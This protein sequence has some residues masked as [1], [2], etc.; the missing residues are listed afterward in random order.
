MRRVKRATTWVGAGAGAAALMVG[1]STLLGFEDLSPI[2]EDASVPGQDADND[3]SAPS[4]TSVGEDVAATETG[5]DSAPEEDSAADASQ[6]EAASEAGSCV[7]TKGDPLNCGACGHDCLGGTCENGVCQPVQL[8]SGLDEPTDMVVFDDS[9]LVTEFYGG[10]IYKIPKAGGPKGT[11]TSTWYPCSLAF[12]S[13]YVYWATCSDGD[14]E[15]RRCKLPGCNSTEDIAPSDYAPGLLSSSGRLFWAETETGHLKTILIG[16]APTSVLDLVPTTMN[17]GPHR[18]LRAGDHVY[19]SSAKWFD[20]GVFRVKADGSPGLE[21]V[22]DGS[23]A[24][25]GIARSG[26]WLVWTAQGL[27]DGQVWRFPIAASPGSNAG[28]VI[29]DSQDDPYDIAAD[30]TKVYWVTTGADIDAAVG[31]VLSCEIAACKT[32]TTMHSDSQSQP[33]RIIVDDKAIYWLNRGPGVNTSK[34]GSLWKLAK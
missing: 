13:Q 33:W 17:M 12:D 23:R 32:T 27:Y 25:W 3:E 19:F 16:A 31:Q 18:L 15:I 9:I 28:E 4:E 21:T 1:C 10:K 7:D 8:A 11:F 6:S 5:N 29:A 26:D 24:V 30:D 34:S 20:R 14:G 22:W 2:A